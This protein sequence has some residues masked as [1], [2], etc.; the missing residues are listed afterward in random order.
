MTSIEI[1]LRG[2]RYVLQGDEG[3]EH[4]NEVAQVVKRKLETC[5][6]ADPGAT[7]TR[8]AMAVA[9]DLASELIKGKRKA[10]RYRSEV[11]QRVEALSKDAERLL[12]S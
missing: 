6:K 8:A 10:M 3:E 5:Y 7:L 12:D 11:T 2:Q 4:L 9:F 1:T